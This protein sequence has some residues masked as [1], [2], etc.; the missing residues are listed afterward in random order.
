MV[1]YIVFVFIS[2]S[3]F[4]FAQELNKYYKKIEDKIEL[5][6][7]YLDIYSIQLTPTESDIQK[8]PESVP[9]IS[10]QD[11]KFIAS[12]KNSYY[13]VFLL[14]TIDLDTLTL[15]QVDLEQS[16]SQEVK[17]DFFGGASGGGEEP[18][19]NTLLSFADLNELYFKNPAIYRKLRDFVSGVIENN[20][21]A[22]TLN[23][24]IED[25]EVASY[26][27]SSA[28]NEDYLNYMWV[29]SRHHYPVEPGM[30]GTTSL[31]NL[32]PRARLRSAGGKSEYMIDATPYYVSFY[33]REMDFDF[34][35]LGAELSMESDLLNLHPWQSMA[36]KVGAR[37]LFT[38]VQDKKN[39]RDDFMIDFKLM[40]RFAVGSEA[41][42]DVMPFVFS[43]KPKLNIGTGV[44]FDI[45][46]TRIYGIPFLNLYVATGGENFENPSVSFGTSDSSYAYFSFN[47][48]ASTMSFYWNSSEAQTFRLRLDIGF[49]G[50]DVVKAVYH[51]GVSSKQVFGKIQ[52][53]IN[54]AFNF[55]PKVKS[56]DSELFASNLRV[57]DSVL[58]VDFWLKLLELSGGHKF[59][60]EIGYIS[61][62][63]FRSNYE[64]ENSSSTMVGVRYRYGF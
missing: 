64:W 38:L 33:H 42:A 21:P 35:I 50:Y 3:T 45:H 48:F 62:P 34:S 32:S 7:D 58:K 43:K 19:R 17:S 15:L 40:G 29:N 53:L 56:K 51:Q 60:F 13:F 12:D 37:S 49:G 23:I 36:L 26:G 10:G 59:R 44:I 28:D 41:V 54:F 24:P 5:D 9:T 57:F 14:E 22:T 8:L 46:T 1:K 47:E 63:F 11:I 31:D 20:E 16:A 52:P 25:D 4:L 2:I 61:S 55:V 6:K 30:R 39:L 27:Y 18:R